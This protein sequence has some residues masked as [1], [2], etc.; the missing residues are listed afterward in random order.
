VLYEIETAIYFLKDTV[1]KYRDKILDQFKKDIQKEKRRFEKVYFEFNMTKYFE[2]LLSWFEE[3]S[4]DIQASHD[5]LKLIYYVR[6]VFFSLYDRENEMAFCSMK[7]AKLHRKTRSDLIIT[8]SLFVECEKLSSKIVD[9]ELEF[10]KFILQTKNAHDAYVYLQNNFSKIETK[11]EQM[12][13][14]IN[15]YSWM[16]KMV[17][18]K[19]QLLQIELQIKINPRN[20]TIKDNF[21]DFVK[22]IKTDKWEKPNF[23]FAQYLDTLDAQAMPLALN[24]DEKRKRN[25]Q[26]IFYYIESLK[27]GFKYIWQSLPRSLELWFEYQHESGDE[28]MQNYMRSELQNLES[29]KLATALQ[30]FL[31]R[32][33]H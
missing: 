21:Q 10:A 3:R 17:D 27:Y 4:L 24:Q 18:K 6:R 7:L 26:K 28:K 23:K 19:A 14:Q 22:K 13:K 12:A 25:I 31:N 9:F 8:S 33:G 30:I 5:S 20:P 16:P 29:F 1:Y 2:K 15:T 11:V 32:F